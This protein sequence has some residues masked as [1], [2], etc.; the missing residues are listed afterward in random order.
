MPLSPASCSACTSRASRARALPTS[1]RARAA[2]SRRSESERSFAFQS[3]ARCALRRSVSPAASA[4][5]F[6]RAASSTSAS[7]CGVSPP[8]LVAASATRSSGRRPRSNRCSV[9]VAVT[10]SLIMRSTVRRTCFA[11]PSSRAAQASRRGSALAR[12]ERDSVGQPLGAAILSANSTTT[13]WVTAMPLRGVRAT[14]SSGGACE[15]A[16]IACSVDAARAVLPR[17]A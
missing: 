1:R 8:G 13:R 10:A 6:A 5:N 9:W 16:A 12:G 14:S 2:S 15:P 4:P 3:A 7:S 11:G 17:T